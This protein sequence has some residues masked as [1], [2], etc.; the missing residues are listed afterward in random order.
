MI[1]YNNLYGCNQ[2]IIRFWIKLDEDDDVDV[3]GD[4]GLN[5]DELEVMDPKERREVLIEAGLDP[6]EFDF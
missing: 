3:V 1:G 4:A 6:S 5:Y 2:E